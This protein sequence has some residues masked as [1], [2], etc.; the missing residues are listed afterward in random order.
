MEILRVVSGKRLNTTKVKLLP[1]GIC[2]PTMQAAEPPS[3][4]LNAPWGPM[5]PQMPEWGCS[6]QG[7]LQ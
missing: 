4:L 2:N 6:C 1:L 3:A 7:P 5:G